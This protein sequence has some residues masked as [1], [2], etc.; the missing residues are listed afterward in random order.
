M[1]ISDWSSDVCSSDLQRAAAFGALLLQVGPG[2]PVGTGGGVPARHVVCVGQGFEVDGRLV[3]RAEAPG[4]KAGH[5]VDPRRGVYR[6]LRG[7][8]GQRVG[9]LRRSEER[10]VGKGCA[11]TGSAR[12]STYT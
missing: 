5:P 12:W 10:R 7:G 3:D 9:A 11:G 4:G 6:T 8:R 1:R 2:R